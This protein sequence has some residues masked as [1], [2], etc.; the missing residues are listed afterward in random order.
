MFIDFV[1]VSNPFRQESTPHPI[2]PSRAG[3]LHIAIDNEHLLP[4]TLEIHREVHGDRGLSYSTLTVRCG[5]NHVDFLSSS[6]AKHLA[7]QPPGHPA[8]QRAGW[9]TS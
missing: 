4:Y 8:T 9:L 2:K 6:I 7:T 5:D 1:W 3:S